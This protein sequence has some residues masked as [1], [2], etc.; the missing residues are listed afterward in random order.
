MAEK[1]VAERLMTEALAQARARNDRDVV[2]RGLIERGSWII[3]AGNYKAAE[4]SGHE[5]LQLARAL[6]DRELIARANGVLG[7]TTWRMGRLDEAKGYFT[8]GLRLFVQLR[9][10]AG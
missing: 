2:V 7:H 6:G 4:A 10:L 1:P 8:E 3:D 9:D 5:A